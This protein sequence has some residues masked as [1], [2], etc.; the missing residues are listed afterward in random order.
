MEEILIRTEDIQL[1]DI[2]S[3]FVETEDDRNIVNTLK[4]KNAMHISW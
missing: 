4:G 1:K 2:L 3:L